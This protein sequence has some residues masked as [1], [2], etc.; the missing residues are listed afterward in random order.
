[1]IATARNASSL[2][3]LK[4]QGAA[5]LQLDVACSTENT[6]EKA[7]EA[8]PIYGRVDVVVNDAG[9]DGL[10]FCEELG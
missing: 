10:G 3:Y 5:V 1:M 8:E 9:F 4:A 7:E 2:E 6:K